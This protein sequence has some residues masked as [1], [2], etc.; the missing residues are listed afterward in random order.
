MCKQG[1]ANGRLTAAAAASTVMRQ[2]ELIA[3][4]GGG[5]KNKVLRGMRTKRYVESIKILVYYVAPVCCQIAEK[6]NPLCTRFKN[7]LTVAFLLDWYYFVTLPFRHYRLL[8]WVRPDAGQSQ[9]R[10]S[11][12]STE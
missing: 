9:Y 8:M 11:S 5:V 12:L 1:F 4:P 6:K 2:A 3:V 10:N 7:I